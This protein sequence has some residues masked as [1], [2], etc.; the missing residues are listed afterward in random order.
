MLR[1]HLNILLD[2]HTLMEK[3]EFAHIKVIYLAILKKDTLERTTSLLQLQEEKRE[4]HSWS[5]LI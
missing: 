2:L 3:R 4:S 1:N 5:L